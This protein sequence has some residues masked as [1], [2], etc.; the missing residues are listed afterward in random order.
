M[1]A[2]GAEVAT[3]PHGLTFARLWLRLN[4]ER[5][6]RPVTPEV[7]GSDRLRETTARTESASARRVAGAG[8]RVAPPPVVLHGRARSVGGVAISTR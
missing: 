8:P 3:N 4:V 5:S 2:R 7:V 6:A 1:R